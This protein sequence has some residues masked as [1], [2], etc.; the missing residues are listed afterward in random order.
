MP[1]GDRL[2]LK[3]DPED[4]TTPIA[5]LLL[6]AV[7]IAKISGLQK[8][9]ILHLW[10]QTYGWI[11]ETGKR[12]KECK[13]TLKEWMEALDSSKSRTS[14]AL[15]ELESKGIMIRRMVDAW[16]GYYYKINTFV[17]KW[18]S[19]SI[20]FEKLSKI[21]GVPFT[22]TVAQN[23]TVLDNDNSSDI[24]NSSVIDNS[25]DKHN[26]TVA[27]NGTE[28]L[29]KTEQHTLYKEILNKDKEISV[30]KVLDNKII[31]E[32][33]VELDKLRGY[34]TTKRTAEAG[35]IKRMLKT[36]TTKQITET[37]IKL[38]SQP[39]WANQELFMMSVESQIGAIIHG[40]YQNNNKQNGKSKI[41]DNPNKFTEGKYGHI[42]QR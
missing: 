4:G 36:Y 35:A 37:W 17:N 11:D 6:D 42:V 12:R 29:P 10:R 24:S 41:N 5:N 20:N 38:K 1:K 3:A 31:G 8:G 15:K 23:G 28:Q 9:A 40:T 33:I 26:G 30:E 16:G 13:I 7:A 32:V 25:T 14:D 34:K 2:I 27:Q 39:F 22:G 18:N 21:T 19:N